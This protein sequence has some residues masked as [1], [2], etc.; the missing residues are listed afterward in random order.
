MILVFSGTTEG[1]KVAKKLLERNFSLVISCATKIGGDSV[2]DLAL[3]YPDLIINKEKLE[4]SGIAQLIKKYN[5]SC[6]IDATHPFAKHIS[7]NAIDAAK[8]ESIKYIRYERKE[9]KQ[10]ASEN[11]IYVGSF[12]EAKE[13]LSK[14]K[15]DIFF[16][17]GANSI[18]Y[19]L[20]IIKDKS[21]N[22]YIKILPTK[23]SLNLCLEAGVQ[24]KQIIASYGSWSSCLI[25]SFIKEKSI[26]I[27]VTKQSGA[28][29]GEL[30]KI[31]AAKKSKCKLVI[32]RKPYIKYPDICFD[33]ECL[34]KKISEYA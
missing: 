28:L 14:V 32:I 15:G 12:E 30:D 16:T 20:D 21:R 27:V 34:M 10:Q 18:S 22:T 5:I 26:D 13:F 3:L 23:E 11:I 6:V 33:F 19:F 1:N 4:T 24:S 7:L 9:I 8:K 25:V 29:G 17:I 2:R 31:N